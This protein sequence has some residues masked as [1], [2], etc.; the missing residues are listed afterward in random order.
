[1]IPCG[2]CQLLES[3]LGKAASTVADA[4]TSKAQ[5]ISRT[6]EQLADVKM[7]CDLAYKQHD[8]VNKWLEDHRRAC[9][10]YY[11]HGPGA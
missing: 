8:K 9:A 7:V 11:L 4:L 5:R 6:S 3:Q 10:L 1:M 2:Q